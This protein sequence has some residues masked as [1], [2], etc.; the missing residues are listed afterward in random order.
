MKHQHIVD[1][2]VLIGENLAQFR[3]FSGLAQFAGVERG[4]GGALQPH[5]AHFGRRAMMAVHL[6]RTVRLLAQVPAFAVQV[7]A[8]A[9]DDQAKRGIVQQRALDPFVLGAVK[10]QRAD[11]LREEQRQRH[12]QQ[13]LP[14]EAARPQVGPDPQRQRTHGHPEPVSFGVPLGAGW[15]RTSAARM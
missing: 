5:A 10:Q 7:V 8:A 1:R 14:L 4:Y 3:L 15:R 13:H 9:G 11:P 2:E 6:R 12:R